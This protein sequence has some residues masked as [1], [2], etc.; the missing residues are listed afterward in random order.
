MMKK[1]NELVKGK[2]TEMEKN[3]DEL[4]IVSGSLA[5]LQAKKGKFEVMLQG[6]E[7]EME[8]GEDA[9]TKKRLNKV[10]AGVEKLQAQEA[11][12]KER[13]AVLS[14][15]ISE[16][17][18]RVRQGEIDE[19]A[20]AYEESTYLAHKRRL[21]E[22]KAEKLTSRLYGMTGGAHPQELQRMAGLRYG[23]HFDYSNPEQ[24]PL[25]EAANKAGA[26]GLAKAEKEFNDL[27]A[28]IDAFIELS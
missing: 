6:L 20:K 27:V 7:L 8:L 25:V 3:Q 24:A 28:K 9:S 12:L 11:E 19:A 26:S 18:A 10:Q 16:E 1:I 17:N 14:Q 21:M 15:A 22:M 13:Q 5:E 2:K 4:Q 23:E